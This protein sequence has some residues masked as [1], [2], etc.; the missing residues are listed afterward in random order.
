[1]PVVVRR[2]YS[3]D[4]PTRRCVTPSVNGSDSPD[5]ADSSGYSGRRSSM[6]PPGTAYPDPRRRRAVA[7]SPQCGS[8]LGASLSL[9][10]AARPPSAVWWAGRASGGALL[11]VA[12]H[13]RHATV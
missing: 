3:E 11:R 9:V 10:S 8:L 1:M 5:D 7:V 12:H 13:L 2:S 4:T 6:S